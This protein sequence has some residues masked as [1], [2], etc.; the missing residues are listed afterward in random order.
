MVIKDFEKIKRYVERTAEL[1][2]CPREGGFIL[3][4]FLSG[5]SVD[6]TFLGAEYGDEYIYIHKAEKSDGGISLHTSFWD[7]EA[8]EPKE[9]ILLCTDAECR[10][11]LYDMRLPDCRDPE[12]ELY[13][14][15]ESINEISELFGEDCLEDE[16]REL[17][18][19][20][21]I[22]KVIFA[23]W[24][25]PHLDKDAVKEALEYFAKTD[26]DLEKR[27]RKYIAR[28][29]KGDSVHLSGKMVYEIERGN[30]KK[31]FVEKYFPICDKVYDT[32]QKN[33]NLD[34][35]QY[36]RVKECII[37][38]FA[39]KGYKGTYPNFENNEKYFSFTLADKPYENGEYR[40]DLAVGFGLKAFDGT[41]KKSFRTFFGSDI[42]VTDI[43]EKSRGEEE[44]REAV[45]CLI[46]SV[47]EILE[48]REPPLMFFTFVEK[49]FIQGQNVGMFRCG[50]A[51]GIL[52]AVMCAL[53]VAFGEGEFYKL[54]ILG[55]I[56]ITFAVLA[57]WC[58]WKLYGKKMK[59]LYRV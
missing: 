50:A 14:L 51:V 38:A 6:V 32:R 30:T 37:S 23:P 1:S 20:A 42:M 49:N 15:L 12:R 5:G 2:V 22:S 10:I 31:T 24:Y 36:Y 19:E 28:L 58:V 56:G 47:E 35:E 45:E 55:A 54:A 57:A 4:G 7:E 25:T 26:S 29:E 39:K 53:L 9:K 43:M 59:F 52:G 33:P 44:I 18:R 17:L 16:D 48:G 34:R 13:C 21:K 3:K 8:G 27:C 41:I 46:W 40:Y 11:T